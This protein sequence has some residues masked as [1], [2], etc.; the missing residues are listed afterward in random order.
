LRGEVTRISADRF[1]DDRTGMSYYVAIVE[2]DEDEIAGIGDEV[3]LYPGMP[4]EVFIVTGSRTLLNYM[5]NPL[6]K[7]FRRAFKEE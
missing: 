6:V 3:H 1:T 4:A 7:S 2:I 5:F